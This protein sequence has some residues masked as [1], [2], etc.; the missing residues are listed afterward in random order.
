MQ[1]ASSDVRLLKCFEG[2]HYSFGILNENYHDLYKT[3][4]S[5][6]SKDNK[7]AAALSKC[8]A[9]IDAVNRIREISQVI[10]GLS[11]KDTNLVNFLRVTVV[12]Q[13]FRHYIQHLRSELLKRTTDPFPVWGTLSWVDPDN[14]NELLIVCFGS[15]ISDIQDLTSIY[16]RH[17][18]DW[19][20]KVSLTLGKHSFNFD[21]IY[22][23][24]CKFQEFIG[25]WI[26]SR[27]TPGVSASLDIALLKIIVGPKK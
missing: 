23:M 1:N 12:A 26:M 2:L 24:T 6:Q 10:P 11:R 3:C 14:R 25:P 20:S 9:I 4:V 21:L 13:Y 7:Y 16:S 17:K 5:I 22:K 8:W 18:N 19:L 15:V 27:Y